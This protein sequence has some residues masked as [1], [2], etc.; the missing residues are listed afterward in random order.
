[1]V[2]PASA[3]PAHVNLP[4]SERLAHRGL[5]IFG[6]HSDN[7]FLVCRSRHKISVSW[8]LNSLFTVGSPIVRC[9]SFSKAASQAHSTNLD[10]RLRFGAYLGR[11][12]GMGAPNGRQTLTLQL[13]LGP[14]CSGR[15]QQT[16][17]WMDLSLLPPSQWPTSATC[18]QNRRTRAK[19]HIGHTLESHMTGGQA[20][21]L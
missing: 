19:S 15:I 10:T 5:C 13:Q 4:Q 6:K 11:V 1:M 21:G 14:R 17:G 7:A 16:P 9:I 3:S 18:R 8:G 20:S 12:T 2:A